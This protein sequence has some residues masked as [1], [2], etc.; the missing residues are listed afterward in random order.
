[1][2]RKTIFAVA[3]VIAC[4]N[5]MSCSLDTSRQSPSLRILSPTPE[6]IYHDDSPV[7]FQTNIL[8]EDVH[9]TLST[10]D[11][12]FTGNGKSLLLEA[13]T[14]AVTVS[15]KSQSTSST[16]SVRHRIQLPLEE[17]RY[18]IV[19]TTQKCM[20]PPGIQY[21]AL[22]ALDGFANS[23]SVSYDTQPADR[24]V[25]TGQSM[26]MDEPVRD[27][28][29]PLTAAT[30]LPVSA[31]RTLSVMDGDGPRMFRVIN[32]TSQMGKAHEVE[33]AVLHEG[34]KYK[35]WKPTGVKIEPAVLA[36]FI[37]RLD[38]LVIPRITSIWGDWTDIDQDGKIAILFCP[39]INAEKL[40][41]GFFN[42]NDFFS[43]NTNAS[44]PH[45]NPNSNEMDILY[46]AVPSD[47][48]E[49]YS[50]ESILATIGHELTHA[51]T[52][53][54]KTWRRIHDGKEMTQADLFLD[55]GWSH[56]SENLCG[57]G[58]SGGNIRFLER[59]LSS[60][61]AYSFTSITDTAGSRG[62]I[63]L[64]L[65]WLFWKQGGMDFDQNGNVVDNG[66]IA[67]LRRMIES[68]H[69]GWEA[70]GLAYDGKRTSNALLG[71]MF[72]AINR[73]RTTA[74]TFQYRTDPATGEPLEVF[75]AMGSV[76]DRIIGQPATISYGQKTPQL[77]RYT[78]G[79]LPPQ[80]RMGTD[81]IYT[82]I[83][84]NIQGEIFFS[85]VKGNERE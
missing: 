21:P 23:I 34:E 35:L 72:C 75:S 48:N 70:I 26:I 31:S 36:G 71:E 37:N 46:V 3:C 79:F 47:E 28:R 22:L 32:T 45:Y 19:S 81:R 60:P 6:W 24:S 13:G 51:I 61:I 30:Q 5:I 82:I 43:R 53:S 4:L 10:H 8:T 27:I 84:G 69:T 40:A 7:Y 65:S 2:L 63:M 20:L 62:A 15:Y 14:Y 80:T 16:F 78:F 68:E 39:T 58:V 44:S 11:G 73:Q 29:I 56:L 74:E 77:P 25:S 83:S 64:L 17:R 38:T 57:L 50:V 66:G 52:F 41:V 1:M 42:P 49:S 9:W 76:G 67:F 59:Y 18:L 54:V 55:E 33:A 85:T 12:M